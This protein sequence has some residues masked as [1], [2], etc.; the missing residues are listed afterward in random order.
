MKILILGID[1]YLGWPLALRMA[2]RGHEV[3]G[4]DNLST[5][6]MSNEVGADSA[7]PIPSPEE[8]VRAAKKYLDVDIKFIIGD[9]TDKD[10]MRT[11]IKTHKPDAIVD[12][13]EQRSAPYSMIDLDHARY[14]MQNNILGTLNLVYLIREIDPSIHI[15]KMGTMGE[16]G[17]PLY[18]IP[19]TAF[20]EAIIGDKKDKIFVPRWA[21]SWYHWSKVFD[22]Y[23][24]VYANTLWK[25][26]IT[27]IMQG[28][29]YG[30]R[31][32]EIIHESLHTRFD[33]DEVWGTVVNRFCVEA[34]LGLA[35]TVYGKGEQKKAFISL[36]D[37]IEALRLLLENPPKQ[38]EYRVVH[39]YHE[40]Y[41][42]NQVA[43]MVKKAGEELGLKIDITHVENPR[44]EKEE[45]EY[46]NPEIKVLPSLG[47]KPKKLMRDEVKIMI[48]DLLPFK[49]RLQRYKN[50]IYPKTKWR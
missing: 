13:A 28:P 24:L 20:I 49:E 39:Q 15:L 1:G 25:L 50:V 44:L 37:S 46:Y 41:S 21:G 43:E 48:K 42:I 14:T 4:V 10:F 17:A 47:F 33:F 45:Q 12:F 7:F 27:D 23:I 38:G 22:T 35:L 6:R 40:I 36:E 29:V 32:E 30:T 5:R 3:I 2:K 18:D 31:T 8:R 34:V 16:Y 9:V 11:I 26:T 19:E